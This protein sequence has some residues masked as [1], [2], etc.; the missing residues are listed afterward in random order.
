RR[1][2]HED[3]ERLLAS[4]AWALV[5]IGPDDRITRWSAVA[6]QTF[7][8]PAAEALGRTLAAAGVVWEAGAVR[9]GI[10]RCRADQATVRLDSVPYRRADGGDGI[11]SVTFDP[12][13]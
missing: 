10:A 5:A 1:R 7:A 12:I 3:T 6:E 13:A 8:I 2:A 11:L 9:D 4:I